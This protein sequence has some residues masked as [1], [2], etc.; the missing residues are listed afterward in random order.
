MVK[1]GSSTSL[2]I[3]RRGAENAEAAL[4]AL[5]GSVVS[6][7]VG[8]NS[9][10]DTENTEKNSNHDPAAPLLRDC[11]NRTQPLSSI[12]RTGLPDLPIDINQSRKFRN[13]EK[14]D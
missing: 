5:R 8:R 1:Q 11:A 9:S 12:G 6:L 3:H 13:M 14:E 4:R 2:Q 10:Q 7:I